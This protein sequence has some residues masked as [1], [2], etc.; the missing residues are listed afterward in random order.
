MKLYGTALDGLSYQ[1]VYPPGDVTGFR[2]WAED[3]VIKLSWRDPEDTCV[4]N[5]MLSK[6]AG[7]KI[8]RKEGSYPV[9]E[10]D[11][12]SIVYSYKRNSYQNTVFMDNL[13]VKPGSVYYY[14]AFPWNSDSIYNRNPVNRSEPITMPTAFTT[15]GDLPIG[16]YIHIPTNNVMSGVGDASCFMVLQHGYPDNRFD[17]T[18]LFSSEIRENGIWNTSGINA[19]AGSTVD[20]WLNEFYFTSVLNESVQQLIEEVPIPYT[21]GNGNTTVSTLNRKVFLL[22]GTEAGRLNSSAYPYTNIEGTA[23]LNF[24]SVVVEP[25]GIVDTYFSWW[26]RSPVITDGIS[27]LLMGERSNSHAYAH[28]LVRPAFTLPS[29]TEIDY[30]TKTIKL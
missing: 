13:D 1:F 30:A 22:S 15:L 17:H 4:D 11:G 14:Q 16:T 3:S 9:N 27:V 20:K 12:Y 28:A 25:G 6:W 10:N 19:Y 23:L 8:V 29:S 26:T 5:A 2:V 24:D 18:L 21:P 7:T